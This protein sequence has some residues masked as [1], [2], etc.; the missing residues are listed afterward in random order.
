MAAIFLL[1][2]KI[3]CQYD[4]LS[5]IK[6]HIAAYISVINRLN[7]DRYVNKFFFFSKN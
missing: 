7:D 5:F 6:C 3:G 2:F 4:R 1:G